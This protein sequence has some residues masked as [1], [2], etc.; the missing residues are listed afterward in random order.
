MIP[1]LFD[2][3]GLIK[4]DN[5]TQSH[6]QCLALHCMATQ[7]ERLCRLYKKNCH[8]NSSCPA[9]YILKKTSKWVWSEKTTI[10]NCRQPRCIVRKSHTTITRRQEDKQSKATSSLSLSLSLFP[11]NMIAKLE[12]TQSYAQQN[13][14]QLQNPTIGVTMNQ[15]QQNHHLRTDS[16]QSHW[17]T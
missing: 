5:L 14:E 6:I 11:I 2:I 7:K 15:Q 10:T 16:S 8:W 13:I 17:G 3:I 1:W 9:E 4:S 12:M